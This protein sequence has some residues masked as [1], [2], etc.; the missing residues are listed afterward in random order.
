M[1]KSSPALTPER[2]RLEFVLTRFRASMPQLA[3]CAS[4]ACDTEHH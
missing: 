2:L 3:F 1:R 4:V